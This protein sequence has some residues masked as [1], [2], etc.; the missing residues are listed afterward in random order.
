MKSS[1]EAF[2]FLEFLVAEL[3]DRSVKLRPSR[4][5]L[6]VVEL[7]TKN[8]LQLTFRYS[9]LLRHFFNFCLHLQKFPPVNHP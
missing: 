4:N 7:K 1:D 6:T 8:D 3:L 5:N 9:D 2:F